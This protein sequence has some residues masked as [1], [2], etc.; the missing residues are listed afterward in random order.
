MKPSPQGKEGEK[1][2]IKA[3]EDWSI[4]EGGDTVFVEEGFGVYPEWEEEEEDLAH[5]RLS[6]DT[7]FFFPTPKRC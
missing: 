4:H 6:I 3:R 1:V 5:A 7:K 2:G